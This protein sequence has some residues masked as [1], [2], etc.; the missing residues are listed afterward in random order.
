MLVSVIELGLNVPS[1]FEA[2]GVSTTGL[3]SQPVPS[4]SVNV[5]ALRTV[6]EPGPESVYV[7]TRFWAVNVAGGG[8]FKPP[9]SVDAIVM[10]P[11]WAAV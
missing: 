9:L 3:L 2:D 11:A 6:P 4:V 8:L 7:V 1:P 5:T 10:V